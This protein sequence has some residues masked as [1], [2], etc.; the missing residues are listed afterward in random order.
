[1][2]Y[3][4]DE[5]YVQFY[6]VCDD[7]Y[8]SSDGRVFKGGPHGI[9]LPY[10]VEKGRYKVR[11]QSGKLDLA[12]I[13]VWS[14]TRLR[15][16]ANRIWFRDGD[17]SNCR[18]GNLIV[19]EGGEQRRKPD[20]IEVKRGGKRIV[21]FSKKEASYCENMSVDQISYILK[22]GSQAEM[23]RRCKPYG[24]VYIRRVKT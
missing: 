7:I 16:E 21:Y 10:V 18:L 4:K 12:K 19:Y 8:A 17:P 20:P 13:I 23:A 11:T 14:F 22:S 5:R 9:E 2:I 15:P 1:M 3:L 24:I 6:H